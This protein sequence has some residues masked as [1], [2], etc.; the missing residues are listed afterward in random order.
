[1]RICLVSSSFYPA[2]FY[3]GPI[4]ATWD[5]SKSITKKNVEVY[6]STTNA[7][8]TSRLFVNTNRFIKKEKNLFVKYYHEEFINRFS[9]KF[10]LGIFNDIKL[11]MGAFFLQLWA[12]LISSLVV[13]SE[14]S[15]AGCNG[16]CEIV[17]GEDWTVSLD[18]HMWDEEITI[19]NLDV[20]IGASLKLENVNISIYNYIQI[21]VRR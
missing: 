1:M 10:V 19:D 2:S 12:F 9:V 14:D 8:G 3:G 11:P 21:D 6:V 16:S 5:L 13:F 17:N 18:T 20:N 7:N 15:E 4:S